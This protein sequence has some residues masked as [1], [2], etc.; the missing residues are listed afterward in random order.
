M[1]SLFQFV[2]P[3]H[4]CGYLPGETASTE[5]EYAPN[6]GR[7]EYFER[8]NEG[9]RRFGRMMFR[10]RCEVCKQC[11]SLRVLVNRFR[12]NRSQRR[13]IG[14]NQDKVRLQIGKPTVTAAKLKLYDRFHAYQAEAK[15]WPAHPDR[16][17][18]SYVE[19][20]VDNPFPVEEWCYYLE[21]QLIGVGYVDSLPGG[22]SAIYFYYDPDERRRSLGTWNV[23]NLINRAAGLRIPFV[24]LG[25][26]VADCTSLAYKAHF[27]PH[28]RLDPDG[29]WREAAKQ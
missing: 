16:D 1:Q 24:Y 23:I 21:E 29:I 12:P 17:V 10:P 9:W 25:F 3:P 26:Y 19:S 28:E 14:I 8:L 7:E 6:V 27:Q 20:F 15:G 22:L 18:Q 4:P 2:T 13:T 5:Y 11:R